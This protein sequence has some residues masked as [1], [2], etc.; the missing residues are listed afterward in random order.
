[1]STAKP[2]PG[3]PRL[4]RSPDDSSIR[5]C[6][7][8]GVAVVGPEWRG[9]PLHFHNDA[10]R[11]GCAVKKAAA[12]VEGEEDTGISARDVKPAGK[13]KAAV[14]E[15]GSD[16][17][18]KAGLATMLQRDAPGDFT[19]GTGLPD[20]GV[21]AKLV[22]FPVEPEQ[23]ARVLRQMQAEADAAGEGEGDGDG[24][25]SGDDATAI[26]TAAQIV[27]AQRKQAPDEVD[28]ATA[29]RNKRRMDVQKKAKRA[30]K[31]GERPARSAQAS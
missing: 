11:E 29:Q 15:V 20:L 1:M 14:T 9:L 8:A 25:E 19:A 31:T 2:E 21:L 18:V 13:T 12:P 23:C 30:Q 16:E 26:K 27:T 10:V 6:V 22:G 3:N 24:E 7:G 5:V 4:Y 17:L 28:L